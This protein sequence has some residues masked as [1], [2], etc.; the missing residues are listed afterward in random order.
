M[1][2]DKKQVIDLAKQWNWNEVAEALGSTR[3]SVRKWAYRHLSEDELADIRSSRLNNETNIIDTATKQVDNVSVISIKDKT[4]DEMLQMVGFNPETFKLKKSYINMY[5][6]KLSLRVEAEPVVSNFDID[7]Y[8]KVISNAVRDAVMTPHKR[9]MRNH[10]G[11]DVLVPLYDVHFGFVTYGEMMQVA[12]RIISELEY[13]KPETVHLVLGGDYFQ[14]EDDKGHTTSG[15][16]TGEL[17]FGKMI[18]EGVSFLLYLIEQLGALGSEVNVRYVGGN[19]DRF[20][21]MVMLSTLS[22]A[23]GVKINGKQLHVM[24]GL[25]ANHEWEPFLIKNT[26]VFAYH[27]AGVMKNKVKQQDYLKYIKELYP[28]MLMHSLGANQ[29]IHVFTGHIHKQEMS[30]NGVKV[31][32]VPV[33]SKFSD[34]E[35]A[36]GFVDS[37]NHVSL[38]TFDDKGMTGV[39]FV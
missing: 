18:T 38:F 12:D 8:I 25:D 14:A 6:D 19:H 21:T 37:N 29:P 11:V 20:A 3:E 26:P 2:Y 23:S 16:A 1:K 22:V 27:G 33:V 36:N 15:T 10:T 32:Q 13:M 17:D 7:N 31:W 9:E 34:Y 28:E 24:R 30:E 4:P 5:G 39:R 35:I